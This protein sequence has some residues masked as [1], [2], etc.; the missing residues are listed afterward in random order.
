MTSK[1]PGYDQRRQL[2]LSYGSHDYKQAAF[3]IGAPLDEAR[4]LNCRVVGVVRPT[5]WTTSRV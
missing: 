4:L 1:K 3:D 5:R 2:Q